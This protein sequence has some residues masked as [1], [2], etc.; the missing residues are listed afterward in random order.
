MKKAKVEKETTEVVLLPTMNRILVELVEESKTYENGIANVN[1]GFEPYCIILAVGDQVKSLQ[2]G[3][4]GLMRAD[5][6]APVFKLKGKKYSILT[7][8]DITA[9]VPEETIPFLKSHR[10]QQPKEPGVLDL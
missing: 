9:V 8:F 10:I 3:T 5:I 4:Y 1:A 6:K 2:V 7:E